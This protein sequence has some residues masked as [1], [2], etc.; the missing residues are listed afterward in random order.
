[1]ALRAADAPSP[2]VMVVTPEGRVL[3]D[4]PWKENG[5]SEISA[6]LDASAPGRTAGE[7][8]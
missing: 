3:L 4:A 6:A 2:A 7:E 5:V 1:M 8:K